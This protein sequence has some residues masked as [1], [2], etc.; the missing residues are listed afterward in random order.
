MYNIGT[1]NFKTKKLCEDFTR[2]LINQLGCCVIQKDDVHFDFFLNLFKNH[3]DFATKQRQGIVAFVIERNKLR[4]MFFQ[5]LVQHTDTTETSFSWVQCCRFKP[6]TSQVNLLRAMRNAIIP[7]V[8]SFR[9]NNELIC[10]SCNTGT[11]G[12]IFHVDHV[13]PFSDLSNAF[14]RDTPHLVPVLFDEN[15]ANLTIFKKEDN[16]F[17]T[18]WSNFHQEHAEL[19]VLC[20]VCNL[21][22]PRLSESKV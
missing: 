1:L 16:E 6:R 17:E 15:N 4:P 7:Q 3:P 2:S 19:Q 9:N 12:T 8:V 22:K 21:K 5:L 18:A 14:L 13:V 10:K 11:D 20:S